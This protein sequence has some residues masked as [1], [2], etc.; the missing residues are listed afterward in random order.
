MVISNHLKDEHLEKADDALLMR[1]NRIVK[2]L[3]GIRSEVNKEE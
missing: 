2:A 3:N 1:Q